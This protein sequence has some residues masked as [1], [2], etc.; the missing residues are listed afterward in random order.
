MKKGYDMD[1]MVKVVD[2][3]S[4]VVIAMLDDSG[5]PPW[6]PTLGMWADLA[7]KIGEAYGCDEVALFRGDKKLLVRV[8]EGCT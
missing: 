8:A 5:R 7:R 3:E 4:G 6:D 2:E 1:H